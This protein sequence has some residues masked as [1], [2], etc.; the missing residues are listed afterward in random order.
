[1]TLPEDV[2]KWSH[3]PIVMPLTAEGN[4]PASE[5]KGEVRK[6][7]W[8]VWSQ[9]LSESHGPFEFLPDAINEAMRLSHLTMCK[10]LKEQSK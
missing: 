1:M 2:R 4:G 7:T 8:E 6:I 10:S 9:D 5:E 3:Y